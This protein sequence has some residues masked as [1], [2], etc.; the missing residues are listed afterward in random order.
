[1]IAICAPTCGRDK[2][3]PEKR[4]RQSWRSR[5]EFG[6]VLSG[7][8]HTKYLCVFFAL[9]RYVYSSISSTPSV[10]ADVRR[11]DRV[12]VNSKARDSGGRR[13]ALWRKIRLSLFIRSGGCKLRICSRSYRLE[14]KG[15]SHS[16]VKER[17]G[18]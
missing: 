18:R 2:V 7:V 10:S 16:S 13:G 11:S 9:N 5:E 1:M 15:T 17:R 4:G 6:F 12:G 3:R 8:T 14:G